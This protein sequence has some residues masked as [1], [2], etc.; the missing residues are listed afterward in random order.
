LGGA[1]N[2]VEHPQKILDFVLSWAWTS[3]PI[4]DSNRIFYPYHIFFILQQLSIK[5]SQAK[6]CGG[7]T[8]TMNH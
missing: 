7:N 1:P 5:W 6:D 8:K 3:S 4:T 2:A